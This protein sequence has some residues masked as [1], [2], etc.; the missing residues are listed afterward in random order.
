MPRSITHSHVLYT[1]HPGREQQH[2]HDDKVDQDGD[3]GLDSSLHPLDVPS[4]ARA[5]ASGGGV[6]LRRW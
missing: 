6:N 2:N 1:V 3:A 4:R 5:F